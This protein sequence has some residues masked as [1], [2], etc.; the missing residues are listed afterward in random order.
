MRAYFHS[1]TDRSH[2][3]WFK[4]LDLSLRSFEASKVRMDLIWEFW[5]RRQALS[6]FTGSQ[7]LTRSRNVS[8]SKNHSS[9]LKSNHWFELHCLDE[10]IRLEIR[11]CFSVQQP[12]SLSVWYKNCSLVAEREKEI[13]FC[14]NQLQLLRE[15]KLLSGSRPQAKASS[16]KSEECSSKPSASWWMRF[17]I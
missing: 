2:S 7:A 14:L 8:A 5:C 17:T 12:I 10:T 9:E 11:T 1:Q 6:I 13:Q 15:S 16:E 4:T 3:D